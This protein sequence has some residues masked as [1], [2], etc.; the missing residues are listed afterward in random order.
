MLKD[1]GK[2]LKETGK[3][4]VNQT[5][6]V[7]E[8]ANLN[9]KIN[10][11]NGDLNSALLDLG[12]EFYI[13]TKG[14]APKGY[15]DLFGSIEEVKEDI[16]DMKKKVAELKEDDDN[17]KE[18]SGGSDIIPEVKAQT[19]QEGNAEPVDVIPSFTVSDDKKED[20]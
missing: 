4:A 11:R 12:K 7:A 16:R 18:T 5:K 9:A 15:E 10:K 19:K 3:N 17:S 8:I 1:F 14:K 2:K 20:K 6:K 13:K